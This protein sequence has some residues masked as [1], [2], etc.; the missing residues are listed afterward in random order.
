MVEIQSTNE[1]GQARPDTRASTK[2]VP[3]SVFKSYLMQ[4]PEMSAEL[5]TVLLQLYQD[6]CKESQASQ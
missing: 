4:N 1:D 5:F 3:D 2:G 6:P